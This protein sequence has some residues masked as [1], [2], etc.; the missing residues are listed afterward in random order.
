ML[1][2]LDLKIKCPDK[3][4]L[5]VGNHDL[6]YIHSS[7]TQCRFSYNVFKEIQEKMYTLI[8]NDTLKLCYFISDNIICSHAGFSKT[9][10]EENNLTLDEELLNSTFKQDLL[11]ENIY[12]YD[13]IF[14]KFNQSEYGDDV[15]QS[16]LW[17]RPYSLTINSPLDT[18]QIVGHTQNN[19]L[20]NIHLMKVTLCDSLAWDKYYILTILDDE[21]N[22]NMKTV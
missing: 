17:I 19:W 13:F 16:P 7:A 20:T 3:V 12:K 18:F 1:V 14:R 8:E 6:S 22:F 5:L 11:N 15:W 9:W 21:I 2:I 4:I 10:L